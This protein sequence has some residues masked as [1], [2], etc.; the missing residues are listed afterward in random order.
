MSFLEYLEVLARNSPTFVLSIGN[1]S[2]IALIDRFPGNVAP[3][4][5]RT[6]RN[7]PGRSQMG[8]M[9]AIIA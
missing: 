5:T 1:G 9:S 8:K 7:D 6:K 2:G 4:N 3:I